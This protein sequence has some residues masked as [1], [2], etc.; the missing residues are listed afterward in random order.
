M[1]DTGVEPPTPA[2]VPTTA[3][4][5]PVRVAVTLEVPVVVVPV[6]T[7]PDT[8]RPLLDS[9]ALLL[10][11]LVPLALTWPPVPVAVVDAAAAAAGMFT[12]T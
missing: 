4:P 11:V 6:A 10:A 9:A 3:A 8:A 1:A 5:V 7:A 2:E 12:G